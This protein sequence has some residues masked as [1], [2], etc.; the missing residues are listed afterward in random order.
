MA[1]NRSQAP[2]QRGSIRPRGGTFQVRVYAG[3]NPETGE[4]HYLTETHT[5]RKAADKA[6]IRLVALVDASK[7]PLS[8]DSFAVAVTKWLETRQTEVD[9]GELS[10]TTLEDYRRL[11]RDH[12]IPVIGTITMGELDRQLVPAV[13]G[14]YGSLIKC[15]LRCR[16]QMKIEHSPGGRGNNRVLRK[17]ELDGHQCGKRCK[18]HQCARMS[19]SRLRSLHAVITGT[20]AMAHR[21]RWIQENPAK[22]IK[23]PKAPKPKPKAPSSIEVAALIKAAF[24][25]GTIVW[26]MLVTGTRRSSPSPNQRSGMSSNAMVSTPLNTSKEGIDVR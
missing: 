16:G 14:L 22:R 23:P 25:Q 6:R 26:I 17:H 18:T 19:A 24:E 12:V 7:A 5:D 15:K 3:T 9:A 11:A 13:E 20:C 4:P 21:W 2:R 1:E 10:P 8:N